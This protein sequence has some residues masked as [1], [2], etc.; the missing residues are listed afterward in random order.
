MQ[1][2]TIG[3][4]KAAV[5]IPVYREL[6]AEL[7]AA[8]AKI[9]QLQSQ[10]D[11]LAKQNQVLTAEIQTI[12]NAHHQS[13]AIIR[14]AQELNQATINQAQE[15]S[16]T[17]INQAQAKIEALF[18]TPKPKEQEEVVIDESQIAH[19]TVEPASMPG[20]MTETAPLNRGWLVLLI[21]VIVIISF[22][23]GYL[24]IKASQR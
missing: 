18:Q 17:T 12:I 5:P 16:Y 11:R 4:S 22:G 21:S 15:Q 24:I 9:I 6:A 8:Q 20:E 23:A 14:E 3:T 13:Q 2:D 19:R 10:N 1:S 7:Q